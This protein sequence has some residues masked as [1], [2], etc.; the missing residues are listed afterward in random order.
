MVFY[1]GTIRKKNIPL[2]IIQ[3]IS[4]DRKKSKAS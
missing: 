4:M 2:D 1:Y 3:V